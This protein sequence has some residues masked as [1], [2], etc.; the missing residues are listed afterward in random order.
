LFEAAGDRGVEGEPGRAGLAAVRRYAAEVMAAHL[1]T[2]MLDVRLLGVA[3]AGACACD[4]R[5]TPACAAIEALYAE[6][7]GEALSHALP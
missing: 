6:V 1:A 7:Y 4:A 3:R 2:T 5:G